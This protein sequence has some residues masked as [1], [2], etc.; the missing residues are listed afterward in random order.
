MGND[1]KKIDRYIS[2]YLDDIISMLETPGMHLLVAPTGTAKTFS[3]LSKDMSFRILAKKYPNRIFIIAC[4]N[5]IQNEQNKMFYKVFCLVGGAKATDINTNIITMVYEK[6]NE[7]MKEFIVNSGKEVTLI[8]DEG[9]QLVSSINYRKE[10]IKALE[11]LSIKS[12]NTVH[13]T[14]TPRVLEDLYHYNSKIKFEFKDE[15][16]SCTIEKLYIMPVEDVEGSLIYQ[17]KAINKKGKQVLVLINS[18]ESITQ[19]KE[20]LEGAGLK[21]GAV[22][23]QRKKDNE[24]YDSIVKDSIIPNDYD[25]VLATSLLECGTNINNINIVP[26]FVVSQANY[27]DLDKAEQGFARL[28]KKNEYGVLLIKKYE[29]GENNKIIDKETIKKT[30]R[31]KLEKTCRDMNELIDFF[32]NRGYSKDDAV[33]YAKGNLNLTSTASDET[34]GQ[35]VIEFEDSLGKFIINE[36]KFTLKVYSNLDKQYIYNVNLLSDYLKGH[37][38]AKDI[39]LREY[40]K[41][42]EESKKE[43]ALIN[44]E[45][46]ESKE[47]ISLGARQRILSYK[48]SP[49]LYEYLNNPSIIEMFSPRAIEDFEFIALEKNQ[50]KILKGLIIDESIGYD[51]ALDLYEKYEKKSDLY[52]EVEK[53][54]FLNNNNSIPLMSNGV[55]KLKNEYGLMRRVLDPVCYKRGKLSNKKTIELIEDLIQYKCF[56]KKKQ[57]E[58]YLNETDKSKKEKIFL[59]LKG[60]VLTRI[61]LIYNIYTRDD[62]RIEITSLK[63]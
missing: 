22:T 19:Y 53:I 3:M 2:E 11:E 60:H 13:L 47:A 52:K 63:K 32:L 50:L 7:A 17:I 49:Y 31:F 27:F 57:Y 24:V 43:L 9:H 37:I 39:V 26:I 14:A 12:F 62:G 23:R 34:L 18:N 6:A 1:T 55:D 56:S 10:S 45:K 58:K 38:K 4:P 40:D 35:G 29:L 33:S 28:R 54:I 42:D 15:D 20:I 59:K 8:I 44:S 48:K 51:L 21:V 30:L 41:V 5:R 61:S 16:G 36:K 25:V 46:K